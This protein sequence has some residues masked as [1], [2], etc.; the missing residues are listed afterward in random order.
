MLPEGSPVLV[1]S[2][3]SSVQGYRSVNDRAVYVILRG[4]RKGIDAA[5]QPILKEP[6]MQALFFRLA[7]SLIAWNALAAGAAQTPA[8][9]EGAATLAPVYAIL[10]LV[11]DRLDIIVR[12]TQTGTHINNNLRDIVPISEPVFDNSAVM[13]AAK[14]IQRAQPK[15]EFAAINT[16]SAAL[17]D[18][19]RSMF[20]EENG[21][22]SMPAAIRDAVRAQGANK[23]VLILKHREDALFKF[24]SGTRDGAGKL[25]GLGFYVDGTWATRTYDEDSGTYRIG[26]GFIAPYA[27]ISVT[28]VDFPSGVVRGRKN[29]TGSFMAGAGGA[30]RDIGEPWN[31]LSSA[32]KVRLVNRLVEREVDAAVAELFAK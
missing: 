19:Q 6:H 32:D 9:T 16:R 21:V 1:F 30:E 17:F 12:R 27:Y 15:A 5:I 2:W 24:A 11:G 26:Q 13:A 31:A 22:M 4:A 28:T 7:I 20:I 23:L 25:E 29:M 14:A 10:S 3:V 18:R 8:S